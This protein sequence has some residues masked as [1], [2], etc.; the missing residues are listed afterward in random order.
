MLHK[1][2]RYVLSIISG[3][4]F[5]KCVDAYCKVKD[6][7]KEELKDRTGIS[8]SNLA[9][10]RAGGNPSSG[11][12]ASFEDLIGMSVGDY[13]SIWLENKKSATQ[14]GDGMSDKDAKFLAWF[15]S[16]P[17][18]TQKSILYDANAPEGL[19]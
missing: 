2:R 8:T 13:A 10:W 12:I 4:D 15:R 18:E 11:K 16:L 5:A 1:G 19:V 14:E 17:I 3:K 9:Q 6:I 7:S